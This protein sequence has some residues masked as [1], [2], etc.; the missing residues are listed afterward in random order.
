ML[1]IT[2]N[3]IKKM[4]PKSIAHKIIRKE[5]QNRAE[6]LVDRHAGKL[7]YDFSQRMEKL[8]RDYKT[9]C[10]GNLTATQQDIL[11][12]LAAGLAAKQKTEVEI[13]EQ[14]TALTDRI[15][16]LHKIKIEINNL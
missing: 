15:A 4:L 14:E 2:L 11:G 12:A 10:E 9:L 5:S 13:K 16:M 1:S 8:V 7:R 6:I 3:V